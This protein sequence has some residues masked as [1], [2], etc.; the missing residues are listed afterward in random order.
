MEHWSNVSILDFPIAVMP[1]RLA[2]HLPC[3]QTDLHNRVRSSASN[4][5][6]Q[7]TELLRYTNLLMS[8][9]DKLSDL[10]N[11]IISV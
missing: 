11:Y 4:M 1:R 7:D 5:S 6:A 2:L 10:C 9:R 8:F 3:A